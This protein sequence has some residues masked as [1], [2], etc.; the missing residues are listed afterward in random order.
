MYATKSTST[1]YEP[2]PA[3]MHHAV[4]Y[5]VVDLGTQNVEWQGQS[6]T[7]RKVLVSWE[8][9]NELKDPYEYDGVEHPARPY[10][11]HKKYTLSFHE[12]ASLLKDLNS[13]RGRPFTDS[14]LSGPPNGFY[15]RDIIGANCFLNVIHNVS[16]SNGKT[17][18]NVASVSPLAKG[19][20]K[21]EPTNPTVFLDLTNPE[22]DHDA[23]VAGLSDGIQETIKLS[24]EWASLHPD[25]Q[26]VGRTDASRQPGPEAVYELDDEI[27]F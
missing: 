19:M 27:P 23:I 11:M 9:P 22:L 15:M 26:S 4:C 20:G 10:T 13:W 14:E 25:P 3:G 12:K 16:D 2:C 1:D 6:K 18:A 17:Y 24:P 7:Q 8:L 5:R 21:L